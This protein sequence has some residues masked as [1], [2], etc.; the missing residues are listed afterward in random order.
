MME[1]I[2][3]RQRYVEVFLLNVFEFLIFDD[4]FRL[5]RTCKLFWNYRI[6][7]IIR[8][9]KT[10]HDP[11]EIASKVFPFLMGIRFENQHMHPTIMFFYLCKHPFKKCPTHNLWYYYKKTH[12]SVAFQ[13]KKCDDIDIKVKAR[14]KEL[15]N[16]EKIEKQNHEKEYER[17]LQKIVSR[18]IQ[19]TKEVESEM[20]RKRRYNEFDIHADRKRKKYFKTYIGSLNENKK[21]RQKKIDEMF[22][23]T[24]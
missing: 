4:L 15:E 13:C 12:I 11:L 24:I 1:S 8:K 19:R 21:I 9:Y 22:S 16:Q 7:L 2:L 17:N 23:K 20:E 6:D 10:I 14:K 5:L 3:S 18:V